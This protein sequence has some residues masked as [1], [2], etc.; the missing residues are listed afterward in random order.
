MD[1]FH[2]YG[3]FTGPGAPGLFEGT[4]SPDRADLL[5]DPN[6][7]NVKLDASDAAGG[8]IT[9]YALENL[10]GRMEPN[11]ATLCPFDGNSTDTATAYQISQ[12][13]LDGDGFSGIWDLGDIFP[14]D[15]GLVEL[16]DFL[17]LDQYCG[18]MGS[19]YFEFD[20][21]RYFADDPRTWVEG[22]FDDDGDVDN[23]DFGILYGNYSGPLAGGMDLQATPEPAT[24]AL[25]GAGGCLLLSRK[26]RNGP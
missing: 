8:V 6:T 10:S 18:T 7:G 26:R 5:Y 23:V 13:D 16:E 19:G 3:S 24:L 25:L 4:D 22:D 20:L 11:D 2:L 14:T 12:T 21:L 9:T 17:S 15:M 1:L